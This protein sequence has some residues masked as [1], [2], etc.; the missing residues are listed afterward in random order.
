MAWA[1]AVLKLVEEHAFHSDPKLLE[2]VRNELRRTKAKS[3]EVVAEVLR[4]SLFDVLGKRDT[5][6][7]P[8]AQ[9][10]SY[11]NYYEPSTDTPNVVTTSPSNLFTVTRGYVSVVGEVDYNDDVW[12]LVEQEL[13][14]LLGFL[15][16][17]PPKR[18]VVD[19]TK[20]F[21]GAEPPVTYLL[22]PFF[23]SD[24]LGYLVGKY[25]VNEIKLSEHL[26]YN[27]RTKPK[28]HVPPSVEVLLLVTENTTSAGEFVSAYL[29]CSRPSVRVVSVDGVGHTNGRLSSNYSEEVSG[30]AAPFFLRPTTFQ[31]LMAA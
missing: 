6:F 30:K 14:K 23:S 4:K 10:H 20:F 25:W 19:L 18:W 31:V 26:K 3:N 22:S 2:S 21:G 5:T 8:G 9:R 24:R 28:A 17:N 15:N 16:N 29:K 12:D 11:L 13:R 27:G 1:E 7:L